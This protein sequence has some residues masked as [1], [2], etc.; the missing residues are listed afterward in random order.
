MERSKERADR[1]SR[2]NEVAIGQHTENDVRS[3]VSK[4]TEV[5]AQSVGAH[6]LGARDSFSFVAAGR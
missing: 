5:D 3:A 6:H 2:L 1:M 4:L